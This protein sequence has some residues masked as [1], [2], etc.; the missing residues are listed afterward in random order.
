MKPELKILIV[1]DSEDDAILLV[2]EI[3]AAGFEPVSKR[4][5]TEDALKSS[6]TDDL[7]DI[8]I[9]DYSMPRLNGLDVIRCVHESGL[10]IPIIIVSGVIGEDMA[11]AAMKAGAHDYLIKGKIARLIP[12]IKRELREAEIRRAHRR[13]EAEIR[14]LNVL[15]KTIAEINILIARQGER[16]TLLD[17]TVK[18]LVNQGGFSNACV[19]LYGSA[20]GKLMPESY[21][22][23]NPRCVAAVAGDKPCQCAC[24]VMGPG[25]V[26]QAV[27]AGKSALWRDTDKEAWSEEMDGAAMQYGFRSCGVFP[28]RVRGAIGGVIGVSSP[29]TGLF[30]GEAAG[31]LDELAGN[32]AHA[33][34]TLEEAAERREADEKLRASERKFRNLLESLPIGIVVLGQGNSIVEVNHA[35]LQMMGYSSKE[36]FIKVPMGDYCRDP[37]DRQRYYDGLDECSP[38]GME[39]LLKRKDGTFFWADVTTVFTSAGDVEKSLPHP[40]PNSPHPILRGGYI[41][42]IIADVTSRKLAEDALI[43]SA[44]RFRQL[45]E[46]NDDAQFIFE[47]GALQIMDANAAAAALLGFT[48]EELMDAELSVFTGQ[49]GL[50]E[51]AGAVKGLGAGGGFRVERM[52]NLKKDGTAITVSIK[53]QRIKLMQS[54]VI[55]CTMRDISEFIRMEEESRSMQAKL[56]HAN[57]MTSLGT[58]AS[59]VAHEINNPNNYI[60]F[61]AGILSG[62]WKDTAKI[63]EAYYKENGEFSAGGMPYTEMKRSVP[64]LLSG[65]T[66]GARRVK[67]IIVNLKDFSKPDASGMGESVDVNAAV[68]TSVSMMRHEIIRYTDRFETALDFSAPPVSGSSQKI[69]QVLINLIINALHSLPDRSKGIS[70]ATGCDKAKEFVEIKIKDEGSGME[71]DVLERITEPFFTTKAGLGGTGLGLSISYSIITEHKGYLEFD[72]KPGVGT[73]VI[74]R[75]PVKRP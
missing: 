64:E 27:S 75:L 42:N 16:K 19:C 12:A 4:V 6:L 72:S 30:S 51:F 10:D 17:E 9:S 11:V 38:F 34:Q 5:D 22:G 35:M 67:G 24:E 1:E 55:Y 58:L 52:E 65:I 70:V 57:K 73:T 54:D 53:G 60:L 68:K 62:V 50:S 69:E 26:M 56:I 21:A 29:E 3:K 61:N 31:I 8:V 28:L 43:E 7:W 15:L 18:I 13:G 71:K 14:R 66:D 36:E 63:L 41:I 23:A 25:L 59:G 48:R 49:G 45:F 37:K 44:E 2:R 40:A 74:V 47:F 33:L 39:I 46:Q 32:V 20:A